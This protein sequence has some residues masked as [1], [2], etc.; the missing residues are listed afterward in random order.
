[1]RKKILIVCP[2]FNQSGYS[3]NARVLLNALKEI[4]D[5]VD[6][7]LLPTQWANSSILTEDFENKEWMMYLVHKH[8]LNL[9]TTKFKYDVSIQL[10]IPHEWNVG[11]ADYNIGITALVETDKISPLWIECINKMDKVVTI[12]EFNKNTILSSIY[13][14]DTG[15][16]KVNDSSKI[17]LATFPVRDE[18]LSLTTED[19]V[20]NFDFKTDFNYLCCAQVGPRKNVDETLKWFLET[21]KDNENVGLVCKLHFMNNS[22]IDRDE[23]EKYINNILKHFPDRKCKLY[24]IHGSLTEKQVHS[25]YIHPKIKAIVST[26]HGESWG[27]PLFEAAYMGLPVIAPKFSGH[28]DFLMQDKDVDGKKRKRPYF[29]DV[30][31]VLKGVQP[32]HLWENVIIKE[33]LWCFPQEGSFKNRLQEVY[34]DYNRFKSQALKL[35]EILK[36]KYSKEKVYKQYTSLLDNF[37]DEV[38]YDFEDVTVK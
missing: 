3:H 38:K 25:L 13:N 17:S 20:T 29:A 4:E 35:K 37:I 7:F 14:S 33:S 19:S 32:E 6:L 11:F 26:T 27:L 36:D 2:A 21:F 24:L 12:S 5:D 31:F 16:L 28:I 15:T 8:Q 23:T 10:M 1:M 34:K 9:Q 30:D 18:F 22:R